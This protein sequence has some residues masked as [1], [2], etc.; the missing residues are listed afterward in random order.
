MNKPEYK[1]ILTDCYDY[2]NVVS[3]LKEKY[4]EKFK[5]DEL[6]KIL[7][8]NEEVYPSSRHCLF[9]ADYFKCP[10]GILLFKEFW[11][12]YHNEGDEANVFNYDIDSLSD[13]ELIKI[14]DEDKPDLFFWIQW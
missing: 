3:Y 13:D 7:C 9:W 1:V 4:P 12:D 6:W 8:R 5:E 14:F 10:S 2:N 11:L